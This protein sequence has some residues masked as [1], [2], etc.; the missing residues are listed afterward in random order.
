MAGPTRYWEDYE[1]GAVYDMGSKTM[2]KEEIIDFA[3]K[4]DP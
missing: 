4:Y 2:T 1:L 3:S